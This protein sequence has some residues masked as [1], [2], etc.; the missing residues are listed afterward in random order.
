MERYLHDFS[1]ELTQLGTT[2]NGNQGFLHLCSMKVSTP[3]LIHGEN[4][5]GLKPRYSWVKIDF[6]N[7]QLTTKQLGDGIDR[8]TMLTA[9]T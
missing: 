2:R 9:T 7:T 8:A 6:G 1:K 4:I 5:G 3:S